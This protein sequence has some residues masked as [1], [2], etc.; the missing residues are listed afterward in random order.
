MP[1]REGPEPPAA[2]DPDECVPLVLVLLRELLL[3]PSLRRVDT[4]ATPPD[5]PLDSLAVDVVRFLRAPV[6][7]S[8]RAVPAVP[9]DTAM[10]RETPRAL[11][12]REEDVAPRA[13][14]RAPDR[15]WVRR[16]MT[17]TE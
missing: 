5:R 17:G 6:L 1:C 4:A 2:P 15:A 8:G 10:D 12:C 9:E 3:P 13:L 11:D 14:S 16:E 7:A